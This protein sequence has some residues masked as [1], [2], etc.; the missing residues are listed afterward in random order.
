VENQINQVKF[1]FPTLS[2]DIYILKCN[3]ENAELTPLHFAIKNKHFELVKYII[4]QM[5][6]DIRMV[7]SLNISIDENTKALEKL[8]PNSASQ[9]GGQAFY[10]DDNRN[11]YHELNEE[12]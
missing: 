7:C 8:F 2:K 6:V 11:D 10:F 3:E 5:K 1:E 4:E 12:C 9:S